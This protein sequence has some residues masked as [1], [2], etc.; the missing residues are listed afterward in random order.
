M[1]LDKKRLP[2]IPGRLL[3]VVLLLLA[4][5]GAPAAA[6]VLLNEIL[7]DPAQDWDGDSAV[8]SRDDEWVEIINTGPSPVSL[9]GY[10]LA[11]ADT[12]WRYGFAGTLGVGERFLVFGGDSYAWEDA[13]GEPRYGLRLANAG[14]E[15]GL[16]LLTASDTTR[17]DVY[18]YLDHEAED[19]RS[20]GR[21]PDGGPSWVLF[22]GLNPYTDT[23][24]PE[25]TGCAPSP[26]S[27]AGC[28]TPVTPGTWGG[29]KQRYLH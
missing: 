1:K 5:R 20:S 23:L 8:S 22:D 27:A 11:G 16:W 7:A 29:L 9:D 12:T 10:R 4:L 28:V 6:D 18:T 3:P 25:G 19:D 24:P 15:I 14:G 2:G 21:L 17:V 26:G 13:N